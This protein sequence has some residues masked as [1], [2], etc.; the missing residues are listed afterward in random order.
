MERLLRR[1]RAPAIDRVL[2]K[3]GRAH[4]PHLLDAEVISTLRRFRRARILSDERA[5]EAVFDLTELAIT[6]HSHLP[7]L[8]RAWAL[9]DRL[10]AYDAM[11]VALADVLGA[12][13]VTLDRR[14]ARAARGIVA[15]VDL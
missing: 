6:R 7:L 12:E 13:L 8:D 2:I 3:S 9:R 1:S 11:Y 10:T 14:L 5:Q 4:A 15:V